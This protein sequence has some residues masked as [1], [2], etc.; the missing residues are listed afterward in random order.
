MTSST[1]PVS[2][3]SSD[4]AFAEGDQ[5]AEAPLSAPP[6]DRPEAA[7]N[8]DQDGWADSADAPDADAVG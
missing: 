6:G 4:P 5:D 1:D 8:P 2:N 3:P 7:P